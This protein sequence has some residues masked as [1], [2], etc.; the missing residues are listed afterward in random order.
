MGDAVRQGAGQGPAAPQVAMCTSATGAARRHAFR[1]WWRVRRQ[2]EL[3]AVRP[4][5]KL[6]VAPLRFRIVHC[7]PIMPPDGLTLDPAAPHPPPDNA[8]ERTAR[9]IEKR[10][11]G[12]WTGILFTIARLTAGRTQTGLGV[13]PGE[14]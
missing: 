1:R 13:T 2:L 8:E 4:S 14:G 3:C 5:I 9:V 7:P 12:Q 11:V 10:I 6:A